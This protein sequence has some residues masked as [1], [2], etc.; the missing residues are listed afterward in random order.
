MSTV[1]YYHVAV[2]TLVGDHGVVGDGVEHD[3]PEGGVGGDLT[4]YSCNTHITLSPHWPLKVYSFHNFPMSVSI[5]SKF[6]ILLGSRMSLLFVGF[7]C[8]AG[9]TRRPGLLLALSVLLNDFTVG[10][11]GGSCQARLPRHGHFWAGFSGLLDFI[12]NLQSNRIPY[13]KVKAAY[14]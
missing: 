5:R 1:T 14:V 4:L 3:P 11:G 13:Y 6:F 7:F 10:E 9:R 12:N 2:V 8:S